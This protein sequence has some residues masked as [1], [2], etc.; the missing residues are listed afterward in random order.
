[1]PDTI[2]TGGEVRLNF[3]PF[4]PIQLR[5][6]EGYVMELGCAPV[7]NWLV[8]AL[9]P[10]AFTTDGIEAEMNRWLR[11]RRFWDGV[12]Y[13]IVQRMRTTAVVVTYDCA[14]SRITEGRLELD[15][16]ARL[17][18]TPE[19]QEDRERWTAERVRR[20]SE[21]EGLKIKARAK[22]RSTLE[23]LLDDQQR[24]DLKDH[25]HFFITGNLGNRYRLDIESNSGNVRWVDA[26]GTS[27]GV[28]CAHPRVIGMALDGTRGSIPVCDAV[29]GQKLMLETD[30]QA[31]MQVANLFGGMY[32]PAT[33]P[34]RVPEIRAMYEDNF[35]WDVDRQNRLAEEL[36]ARRVSR[37][38]RGK[39]WLALNGLYSG[40]VIG[41]DIW[42]GVAAV[43]SGSAT[44]DYVCAGIVAAAF[45]ASAFFTLKR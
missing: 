42:A 19:E 37:R 1:M 2:A 44:W 38:S 11:E 8:R 21:A 27:L 17:E 28:Y 29:I 12:N 35:F 45:G 43:S 7:N 31:F 30:E 14:T 6:G 33:R 13:S 26:A 41:L 20:V 22:A 34:G 5:A 40:T 9:G 39:R 25:S 3:A 16:N 15:R 24:K 18:L 36:A 4:R 23:R 10:G 32:P